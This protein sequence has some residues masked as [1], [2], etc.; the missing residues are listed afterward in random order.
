MADIYFSQ[1]G[2]LKALEQHGK[3]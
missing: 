1:G 2:R 3:N